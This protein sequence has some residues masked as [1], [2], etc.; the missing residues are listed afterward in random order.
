MQCR[1]G[2][3][4]PGSHTWHV[5]ISEGRLLHEERLLLASR[6]LPLPLSPGNGQ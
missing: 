2:I 4:G 5:L 3:L 6:V 1:R